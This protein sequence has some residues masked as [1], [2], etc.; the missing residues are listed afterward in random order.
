[1]VKYRLPGIAGS[2]E[3]FFGSNIGF[4]PRLQFLSRTEGDHPP[5]GDRYFLAGLGIPAGTLVLVAQVEV[6]ETGE[7]HLL[8][9][10]QGRAHLLEEQVHQ[11][12]C[13]PFV[14][15]ELVE[16][17]F[18]HLRLGQGH[19]LFSYFC[20][21]A[22]A[23]IRD[24]RR[25]DGGYVVIGKSARNVLKNQAQSDAFSTCFYAWAAIHVKNAEISQKARSR[26]SY[27]LSEV[28]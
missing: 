9:S 6:A 20:V 10:R 13:L 25:H 5:G 2:C 14:E 17:C 22:H 26:E 18:R 3:L 7:L 15:P 1:M 28:T 23:Q 11:L 27:T 12:P 19:L 8:A 24:D 21:Q 16:E 4:D